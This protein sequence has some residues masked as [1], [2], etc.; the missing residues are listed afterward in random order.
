LRLEGLP[1]RYFS[2]QDHHLFLSKI[3]FCGVLVIRNG[4]RFFYTRN[5]FSERM[6]SGGNHWGMRHDYLFGSW[7]PGHSFMERGL[8]I[9]IS[10]GHVINLVTP[11]GLPLLISSSVLLVVLEFIKMFKEG[12]NPLTYI[13][14]S[15]GVLFLWMNLIICEG[16]H[17]R[18]QTALVSHSL[19]VAF[20]L[21]IISEIMLFCGLL[22]AYWYNIYASDVYGS[23]LRGID[24]PYPFGIPIFGTMV[25]VSSGLCRAAYIECGKVRNFNLLFIIRSACF[26]VLFILIQA[27]EFKQAPFTIASGVYRSCFF[28]TCR[29][30]GSHV[31]IVLVMSVFV[32]FRKDQF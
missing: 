30:H 21:Y 24:V 4:W 2:Y 25:L 22:S 5:K 29:L 14:L 15:V 13:L 32:V 31:F 10:K 28:L 11:S 19:W 16:S 27:I 8:R 6:M 17:L 23:I 26:G 3:C 18:N 20:C 9:P 12:S 1:R 7:M